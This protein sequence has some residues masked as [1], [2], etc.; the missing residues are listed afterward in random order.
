MWFRQAGSLYDD[1]GL[2]ALYSG[3]RKLEPESV[4]S[5]GKK[6]GEQSRC[7]RSCCSIDSG[8]QQKRWR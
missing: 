7:S 4:D 3:D 5:E 1:D 2:G 8:R 6:I